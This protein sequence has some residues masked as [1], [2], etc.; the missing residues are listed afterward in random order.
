MP[1]VP[2]R[3]VL[4]LIAAGTALSLLPACVA[5]GPVTVYRLI[6]HRHAVIGFLTAAS[7]LTQATTSSVESAYVE[8][9]RQLQAQGLTA[10]TIEDME[11]R[12]AHMRQQSTMLSR[13][14]DST[15]NRAD[16]LFD[17]MERRAK[18]NKSMRDDMLASIE[19][20]REAFEAQ[21][22]EARA[23]TEQLETSV[24]H[25]DDVV[26]YAQVNFALHGIDDLSNE[27]SRITTQAR[28]LNT[29]LQRAIQE[30]LSVMNAINLPAAEPA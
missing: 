3:L 7:D 28:R 1:F 23:A 24:P 8:L 2:R 26:G 13:A 25:Y 27:V 17:L 4:S 9:D 6:R 16:I 15:E 5:P 21:V 22:R 14:L 18:E 20:K 11:A 29:E 30:G 19:E 10:Q 12:L